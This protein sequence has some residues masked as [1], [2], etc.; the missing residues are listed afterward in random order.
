MAIKSVK[1]GIKFPTKT[2]AD[3]QLSALLKQIN[4]SNNELKLGLDISSFNK[5]IGEMSKLLSNL[6]SKL[7]QFN[8]LESVIT[9]TSKVNQTTKAI[10]EQTEA[11]REQQKVSGEVLKTSTTK[12]QLP[13]GTENI[14]KELRQVKDEYGNII[15]QVD[16]YNAATG[17]L[18]STVI[19]TTDEVEKNRKAQEKALLSVE[20]FKTSM[21]NKLNTSANN[22]FIDDSVIANLQK[23][24]NS[25]DTNTSQKEID[26]LKQSIMNLSSSDSAIVRLQNTISKMT[27]SLSSLKGKYGSLVGNSSSINQLQEYEA[28]IKRLQSTLND[29]MNGKGITN[30]KV[31]SIINESTDASRRLTTAV[32]NSSDA[33][34]M[35]QKDAMSLGD[36]FKRMAQ[37][38]G[39]FVSTAVVMNQLTTQIK[40]SIG[41]VIQLDSA[42]TN[43]KKVT[44]ETESTYRTFLGTAHEMSMEFG[45]Q[46]DKVVDAV[47]SWAKTGKTLQEATKLAESTM[48]LTKVGD[49]ESV[50]TAQKF[51]IAPIKAWNMEAEKSIELVDKYNNLSNNM[52]VTSADLGE[53][54]SRSA[55]S[56]SLAGNSLDETVALVSVAQSATQAGGD[57]VGQAL[58]TLSMRINT[59]KDDD[60]GE[61]FPTL[62]KDLEN[63]GVKATDTAGQMRSTYDILLDL[64]KVWN[65]GS[66]D[67]NTQLALLEQLAGKRQANI[68]GAILSDSAEIE[69]A[70][71]LASNSANS[72]M[73][74]FET[75]QESIQYSVDRLKE[76]MNELYTNMVDGGF[77]KGL[78]ELGVGTLDT[79]NKISDTFGTLPSILAIAGTAFLTF[80]KN[81][82]S[83]IGILTDNL[84][85]VGKFKTSLD[86]LSRGYEKQITTMQNNIKLQTAWANNN[87]AMGAST[88]GLGTSLTGLNAKLTL[89]QAKLIATKVA[90]V[91]LQMALSFGLSV[92]ITAAISGI[93]WLGKE[94]FGTGETMADCAD[95]AKTLSDS[96]N[97]IGS[98][99]DLVG[100]YEELNKKLKDTTISADEVKTLNEQIANVK[101]QLGADDRYYWILNDESK[102]LEEQLE[103]MKQ[104]NAKRIE[105]QAKDLD[106]DMMSQGEANSKADDLNKDVAQW[107]ELEKA[108]Q[109]ADAQGNTFYKGQAT[110]GETLKKIQS[111]V[112]E[113]I[114]TNSLEV[115][116][117]NGNVK[118]LDESGIETSRS[119][120]ELSDSVQAVSDKINKNT[121]NIKANTQAKEENA[122]AGESTPYDPQANLVAATQEYSKASA[123]A[124]KLKGYIDDI[125]KAGAVTP[126]I[127]SKL[128]SEY[129][130]IGMSVF[131]TASAI[132]FLNGKMQKQV[133]SQVNAMQIMQDNDASFYQNKILNN[134]AFTDFFN[135]TLQSMVGMDLQSAN[136]QLNQF[137]TLQQ[138]KEALLNQFG[139]STANAL[140]LMLQLYSTGY[141]MDL[142]NYG[143]LQ[144]AKDGYTN[145]ALNSIANYASSLVNTNASSYAADLRNWQKQGIAKEQVLKSLNNQLKTIQNN[146]NNMIASIQTS[147]NVMHDAGYGDSWQGRHQISQAAAQIKELTS[148]IGYMDVAFEGFNAGL[149]AVSNRYGSGGINGGSVGSGGSSGGSGGSGSSGKTPEEI[150]QDEA[151]ARIEA[152]KKANQEIM[153][154]R[155]KLYQALKKKYEEQRD[156]ELSVVD[157]EIKAL[158]KQLDKLENGYATEEEKL[159]A[160][161]EEKAKWDQDDSEYGKSQSAKIQEEIEKQKLKV[162]IEGLEDQKETINDKYDAMLE[163]QKLYQEID[164]ML[165]EKQWDKIQSLLEENGDLFKETMDSIWQ[166]A[167]DMVYR[168]KVWMDTAGKGDGSTNTPPPSSGG[169]GSSGGSSSG[170]SSSGGGSISKGDKV[171]VL[172]PSSQIY[173]SSDATR[174][175]G[176]WKGA[177]ISSS[178]ALYILNENLG[179]VAL[180]RINGNINSAI[181]W[182]PKSQIAKYKRGGAVGEWA[183]NDG[184]IIEVHSGEGILTKEQYSLFRNLVDMLP[185]INMPSNNYALPTTNN[186]G[187]IVFSPIITVNASSDLDIDMMKKSLTKEWMRTLKGLGIKTR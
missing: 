171:K 18:N 164:L 67:K 124:Q 141:N 88:M 84:G 69:R 13:S 186:N 22:S 45:S 68:L 153:S 7:G 113:R 40:D 101:A 4:E 14:T 184:K 134:Q 16:N 82:S 48:L 145:T 15:Q 159:K 73:Q 81:A 127:V 97:N 9:D 51:M 132:E 158:Q 43:L 6:K 20:K 50:D 109:S 10:E 179:R 80:N 27:N 71:N 2:E 54:L 30:S 166:L 83:T 86:S 41:Y 103:L 77:L 85:A 63:V 167:N 155:D 53:A 170:G 118:L 104:V 39:I 182:I 100:Q 178:D 137:T 99:S 130:D 148:A 150:A 95:Q 91:G 151:N 168:L 121:E 31:T 185:R 157:K 117:Y 187:D 149:N 140:N 128:T 105:S 120:I 87:K 136:I 115:Q 19:T 60:T 61:V 74:E 112:A 123:E 12:V 78:T 28:Q 47:T 42:M 131:D 70:F 125:N 92:A 64:S 126:E 57:V 1:I 174:S 156:A 21:Q 26:E 106:K 142:S 160:L 114:K 181:G 94:L 169:S 96:L 3:K 33:L 122:N 119:Q 107:Q 62:A 173:V 23:K 138:L 8:I 144:E 110:K 36:S 165:K 25:V 17:K 146:Y 93:T 147:T 5:S 24:L 38:M 46:S 58:K 90:S 52:A 154:M 72:A 176:T 116:E 163:D 29:T 139:Q 56:M 143:S 35:T 37:N 177:G 65:N 34:K 133:D 135:Q 108:I 180:G 44:S 152:E 183:G 102:T 32:K 55:S 76:Q 129:N 175:S 59:F 66:M 89:T 161:E 49:I 111:D 98:E 75:Y 162:Q 172:D 79:V 11:I